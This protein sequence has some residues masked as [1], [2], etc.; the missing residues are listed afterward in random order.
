MTKL[1]KTCYNCRFWSEMVAEVVNGGPLK[2]F[3]LNENSKNY[4][5]MT[6][7]GCSAKENGEPI[8]MP[9]RFYCGDD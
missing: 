7:E 8:D 6:N 1:T 5:S 2:A 4:Q 9:G 3:C